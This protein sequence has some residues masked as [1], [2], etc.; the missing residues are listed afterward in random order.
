MKG[1]F[2]NWFRDSYQE[3]FGES[4]FLAVGVSS[5][6]VQSMGAKKQVRVKTIHPTL[7]QLYQY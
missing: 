5:N 7:A 2:L 6:I 4:V 3:P 1:Q